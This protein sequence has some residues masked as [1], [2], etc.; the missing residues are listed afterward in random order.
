LSRP[1]MGINY[2]PIDRGVATRYKLPLDHGAWIHREDQSGRSVNAILTD[3]PADKA[4]IQTGDIVTAIEGYGI[5]STHL[6]EDILVRYAPGRTVSVEVY[7]S[8]QYL[9]FR[10]TLGTRPT[11]TG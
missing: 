7:R 4:G 9:I 5:D 3:G 10:V 2:V 6:L 8:G 1:F 11:T